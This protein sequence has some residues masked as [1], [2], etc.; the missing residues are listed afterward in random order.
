MS[1]K[2]TFP[3][4]VLISN[5]CPTVNVQVVLLR[6]STYQIIHL[7]HSSVT[8]TCHIILLPDVSTTRRRKAPEE[9]SEVKKVHRICNSKVG[10]KNVG[11]FVRD[12][13]DDDDDD[14]D[15]DKDD[16]MSDDDDNNDHDQNQPSKD[17]TWSAWPVA[18]LGEIR[19]NTG[20][21]LGQWP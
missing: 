15:D 10:Q 7:S 14:N 12:D 21:R 4:L 19:W 17:Y 8:L 2:V 11:H 6:D 16:G 1:L 20:M 13:G 18:L 5:S 3:S 9:T